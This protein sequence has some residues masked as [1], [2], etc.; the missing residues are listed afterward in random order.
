MRISIHE[1]ETGATDYIEVVIA[2]KPLSTVI[3]VHK[4]CVL[5]INGE[6]EGQLDGLVV[7]L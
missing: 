4:N 6:T 5:Y 2:G 1:C 7:E 3:Y